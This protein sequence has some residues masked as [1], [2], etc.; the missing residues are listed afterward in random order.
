MNNLSAQ[1]IELVSGAMNLPPYDSTQIC[2]VSSSGQSGPR[3]SEPS[4]SDYPS[5]A[6][7]DAVFRYEY[8]KYRH[9]MTTEYGA[10]E[11][12]FSNT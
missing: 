8:A 1:Q 12:C 6:G 10:T 2:V 11:G 3:P 5:G 9:V 4:R 7:G